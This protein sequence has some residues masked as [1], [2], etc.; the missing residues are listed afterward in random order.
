MTELEATWLMVVTLIGT[1]VAIAWGIWLRELGTE[2]SSLR[3]EVSAELAELAGLAE[4][5]E[6][7]EKR[8][9]RPE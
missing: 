1:G 6:E 5:I 8:P 7:L 2:L 3:R 9:G 4:R